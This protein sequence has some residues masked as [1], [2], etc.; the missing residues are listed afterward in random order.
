MTAAR[1]AGSAG[2]FSGEHGT[3]PRPPIAVR[4]QGT[5]TSSEQWRMA[6]VAAVTATATVAAATTTAVTA[7]SL[8]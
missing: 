8:V 5:T 6:T 7:A 3:R 2:A 1:V 4:R